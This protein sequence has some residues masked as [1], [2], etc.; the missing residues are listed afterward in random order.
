MAC[1]LKIGPEACQDRSG[2]FRTGPAAK[3]SKKVCPSRPV[4]SLGVLGDANGSI[5]LIQIK[6]GPRSHPSDPDGPFRDSDGTPMMA[7]WTPS[8]RPRR[9]LRGDVELQYGM[10]LDPSRPHGIQRDLAGPTQPIQF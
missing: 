8:N 5:M 10:Q 1:G 9:I 7:N 3:K 4:G 6:T 2:A